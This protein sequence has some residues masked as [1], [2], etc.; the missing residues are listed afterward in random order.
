M[1]FNETIFLSTVYMKA[2]VFIDNLLHYQVSSLTF[3]GNRVHIKAALKARY[4]KDRS[5]RTHFAFL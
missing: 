1:V 2:E 4:N 3:Y 5:E